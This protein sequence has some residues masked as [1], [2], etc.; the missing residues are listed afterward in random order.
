M[1]ARERRSSSSVRFRSVT[2]RTIISTS[3]GAQTATRASKSRT[4][5][6]SVRSRY[7]TVRSSPLGSALS[8]QAISG[9]ATSSGRMAKMLLPTSVSGG[10]ASRPTSPANSRYVPS[11]RILNIAFRSAS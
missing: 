7:S 3:S 5:S 11:R 1:R 10:L 6:S 2:S 9:S 4:A 8:A